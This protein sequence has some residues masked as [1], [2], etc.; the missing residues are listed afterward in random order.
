MQVLKLTAVQGMQA[1]NL[2]VTILA[3]E[4]GRDTAAQHAGA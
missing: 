1:R 4:L 2:A 3:E